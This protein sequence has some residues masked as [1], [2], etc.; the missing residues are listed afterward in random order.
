MKP[1]LL[2]DEPAVAC[3]FAVSAACS[4]ATTVVV[5][6]SKGTQAELATF[7]RE[8]RNRA[9]WQE[10]G[11]LKAAAKAVEAT[12][13]DLACNC[14]RLA[15]VGFFG[16]QVLQLQDLFPDAGYLWRQEALN[17]SG[18]LFSLGFGRRLSRLPSRKAS[19]SQTARPS[20]ETV[21]NLGSA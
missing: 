1:R 20:N 13:H 15:G 14:D 8:L 4:Y 17:S 11:R 9:A 18:F 19:C 12:A 7:A 5:R 10:R 21:I 6:L 3:C 2:V 16:D